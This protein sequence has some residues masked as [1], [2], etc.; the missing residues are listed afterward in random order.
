MKFVFA[1]LVLPAVYAFTGPSPQL[2][3]PTMLQ[4]SSNDYLGN[5]QPGMQAP[6]GVNPGGPVSCQHVLCYIKHI[7]CILTI[8]FSVLLLL[9]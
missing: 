4:M 6:P 7:R 1:A 5:L 9:I 2:Q 8:S 3:I